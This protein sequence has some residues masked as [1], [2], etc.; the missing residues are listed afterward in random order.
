[1]SLI[2]GG[3]IFYEIDLLD[4]QGD[5]I[6]F[7]HFHSALD[8]VKEF[9]IAESGSK[10]VVTIVLVIIGLAL[11][12]SIILFYLYVRNRKKTGN[13]GP[14]EIEFNQLKPIKN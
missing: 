7:M 3:R 13:V 2:V 4:S 14:G 10:R 12:I 8:V 6:Q 5:S 11:L 9:E 1:M